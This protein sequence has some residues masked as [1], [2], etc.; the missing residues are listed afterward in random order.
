MSLL[1]LLIEPALSLPWPAWWTLE[2]GTR[3]LLALTV[4]LHPQR[5]ERPLGFG[6]VLGTIARRLP[7]PMLLGDFMA[8][9]LA[10]KGDRL[11]LSSAHYLIMVEKG[12]ENGRGVRAMPRARF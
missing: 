6:V 2:A 7:W 3:S 12:I 5:I 9:M 11:L 8:A 1:T 4:G 10:P